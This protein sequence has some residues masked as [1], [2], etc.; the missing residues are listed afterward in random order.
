MVKSAWNPLFL[1]HREDERF[2]RLAGEQARNFGFEYSSPVPSPDGYIE[3]GME[4]TAGGIHLRVITVPGHSR[5]GVAF[6]NAA[7]GWVFTGDSLFAGGIG[8]TDL[9]GGDYDQLIAAIHDKLLVL[10]GDTRVFP[11]HGPS[12]TIANELQ[13]N[14]FL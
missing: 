2:I 12:S 8:R 1:I 7:D 13:T 11:G 10:P 5:G 3:D 4:I 9:P 6:Y 14:P